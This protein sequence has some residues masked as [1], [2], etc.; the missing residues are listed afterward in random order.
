MEREKLVYYISEIHIHGPS[1]QI[2][3][4][5][6]YT[7]MELEKSLAKRKLELLL[8]M[9]SENTNLDNIFSNKT[10]PDEFEKYKREYKKRITPLLDSYNLISG[11]KEV[12]IM[13]NYKY[14][15][16]DILDKIPENAFKEDKK[17]NGMFD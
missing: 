2:E 13:P 5:S 7:F 16:G 10:N 9:R 6:S 4:Y 1:T 12:Y 15:L 3:G 17:S 14:S 11:K 8:S